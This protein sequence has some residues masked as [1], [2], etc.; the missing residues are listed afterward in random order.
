MEG[1]LELG[2]GNHIRR[3]VDGLDVEGWGVTKEV[4]S[5]GGGS[6][7]GRGSGISRRCWCD[8][9]RRKKWWAR[10]EG[11]LRSLSGGRVYLESG[12]RDNSIRYFREQV[13]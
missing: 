2:K 10:R 12:G 13:Y 7:S 5:P 3:I 8:E 9:T 1:W 6:G 11:R 4:C